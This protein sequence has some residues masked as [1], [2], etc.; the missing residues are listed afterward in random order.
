VDL[1]DEVPVLVGHVLEA[2]ISQD[3]SV[4]DDNVDAA[5]GLDSRL[6]DLVAI[7]D[8]VVVGSGFATGFFDLINN[9]IGSL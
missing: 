6:D 2:D 8:A 4:V 9:D 1:H 3:T 5:K 7:L